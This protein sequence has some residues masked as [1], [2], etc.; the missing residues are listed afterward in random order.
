M[1]DGF[2]MEAGNPVNFKIQ[3][4]NARKD[5]PKKNG[6]IDNRFYFKAGSIN[7]YYVNNYVIV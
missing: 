7:Q 3:K 6:E 2:F 1:L 4:W 5:V